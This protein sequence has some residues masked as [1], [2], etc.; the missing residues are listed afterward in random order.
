[1]S[2]IRT[3]QSLRNLVKRLRDDLNNPTKP[4]QLILLYAYNRTGKT[5]LSM[6]FKDEGKRK[7]NNISDTL[8]FNAFTED[9]SLGTT[10]STVILCGICG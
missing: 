3:Y 7:N 6:E 5:R 2:G 9:L 10:I 8:Y 4:T 1:M